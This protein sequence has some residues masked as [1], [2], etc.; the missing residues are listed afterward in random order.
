MSRTISHRAGGRQQA[1]KSNGAG[2]EAI[3]RQ[4]VEAIDHRGWTWGRAATEAGLHRSELRY[5]LRAER[6]LRSDKL[7]SLL[8]VCE[9]ELVKKGGRS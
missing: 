9:L 1:R 4:V 8:A 5:W 6:G 3:R 7:A 2:E